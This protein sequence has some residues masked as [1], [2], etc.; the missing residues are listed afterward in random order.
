MEIR[1]A[2]L[3]AAG[4]PAA[5]PFIRNNL[6]F[7]FS[8]LLAV[9]VAPFSQAADGPEVDKSCGQMCLYGFLC[10]NDVD[11]RY[12]QVKQK[13]PV[14]PEGT[15]AYSIVKAAKEFGID[16]KVVQADYRQLSKLPM[17]T[18]VHVKDYH[19]L[20][21]EAIDTGHFIVLLKATDDELIMIDPVVGRVDRGDIDKFCREWSGYVIVRTSSGFPYH[22]V[23]IGVW[24][25][26]L[27]VAG[28][29]WFLG[30][31]NSMVAR[32][33]RQMEIAR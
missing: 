25:L 13:V 6:M 33:K 3:A 22:M 17:P 27:I 11:V 19:Q 15:D 12:D 29:L 4:G 31:R 24:T 9:L 16:A 23:A 30:A 7:E 32:T 21:S 2:F 26:V 10:L 8:I 1:L 18:I 14:G 28:A 20:G 5:A